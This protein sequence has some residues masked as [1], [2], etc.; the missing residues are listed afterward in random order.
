MKKLFAYTIIV[1]SFLT[2]ATYAQTI[3]A[4]TIVKPANNL[5]LVGYWS[6]NEGTSTIATDFSGNGNTSTLTNMD[7]NTDWVNGKRGKALDFDGTNDYVN[8]PSN[9]GLTTYPITI[10]AWAKSSATNSGLPHTAVA[11]ADTASS[12]RMFAIGFS[13]TTKAFIRIGNIAAYFY[14]GSQDVIDGKWHHLVGVFN[15]ATDIRLYVDGVLDKSL[16][17]EGYGIGFN[18][19]NI[20]RIGRVSPFG[21]MNGQVDEVRIYN[22][23]LSLTEIKSLYSSGAAQVNASQNTKLTNGLVGLWSLDGKDISG[24]TAYNRAP[25]GTTSGT[26]TNGPKAAVGK[27]GQALSFDGADDYVIVP[28]HTA[29][30]N[31]WDSGGTISM[32][33]YPRTCGE[34]NAG[35]WFSKVKYTIFSYNLSGNTCG[36]EFNVGWSASA[37]STAKWRGQLPVTLNAWNHIV[38][39]YDSDNISNDPI[40]YVNNVV[41]TTANGF[42]EITAP[43]GTRTSDVGDHVYVG[44]NSAT[45]RAADSVIDEARV[46][47]R[48]LS[49]SEINQLYKMG[50]TK[51]NT[52]QNIKSTSGLVGLW[53][54]NGP[55]ISGTTAYDRSGQGN[56]GTITGTPAKVIGKVGQA[57][58]FPPNGA[59]VNAGS[60]AVFDNMSEFTYSTW[61][62]TDGATTVSN[63]HRRIIALE[64]TGGAFLA[65]LTYDT[66]T[67]N[68]YRI[69]GVI[70]FDT[71]DAQS[72]SQNYYPNHITEWTHVAMTYSAITNLVKLYI[73]GVEASYTSQVAGVGTRTDNSLGN[74]FIGNSNYSNGAFEGSI[75]E[76]RIYNKV[77]TATEIK[78]LYL[79][80]K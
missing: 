3:H 29:V 43:A 17:T 63:N 9:L 52:S 15:S 75:D 70:D 74:L 31:I 72:F 18:N 79:M 44:S 5:G 55:D 73:N 59:R 47:N 39:V 6:L 28:D 57:M 24:T 56:N 71:T 46:Y 13:T 10:S 20:G 80:G 1:V 54:F 77:L 58:K 2:I 35:F 33:I 26:L 69:R 34:S 38:V 51:V 11:L 49:A 61:F 37:A 32:W 41:Y 12:N 8:I 30:Q 4:A 21:Y 36:L 50:E 64:S 27:I 40:A 16:T 66:N 25:T 45:S 68:N 19:V 53:S 76:A 42:A 62:K 65:S 22:R 48:V 67:F 7:A 78:Q 23:A 60:P 14:D